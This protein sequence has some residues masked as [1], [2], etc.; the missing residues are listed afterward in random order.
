MN[1]FHGVLHTYDRNNVLVSTTAWNNF[2]GGKYQFAGL[3]SGLKS[4]IKT[5][6][7]GLGKTTDASGKHDGYAVACGTGIEPGSCTDENY[8]TATQNSCN[9]D[10]RIVWRALVMR[11]DLQGNKL[12]HVQDNFYIHDP[13]GQET[14]VGTGASEYLSVVGNNI[15]SLT[16]EGFGFA[17][18]SYQDGA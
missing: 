7:W 17:F 2:P 6:C 15:V 10:P 11:L 12:W 18:Y 3:T 9:A 5:E 13:T 4:V 8:T 14:G 1:C 16:D